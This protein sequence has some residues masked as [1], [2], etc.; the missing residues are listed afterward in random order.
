MDIKVLTLAMTY[1]Q[2]ESLKRLIYHARTIHSE[3]IMRG[4]P[5]QIE[6][7]REMLEELH[8]LTTWFSESGVINEIH[9]K[10]NL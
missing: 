6:I 4:E 9:R 8:L 5:E 7:P 1:R 10:Q 2:A 3:W